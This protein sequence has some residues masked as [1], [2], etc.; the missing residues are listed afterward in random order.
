MV[1]GGKTKRG[2]LS[3]GKYVTAIIWGPLSRGN[4]SGD[5]CLGVIVSGQLFCGGIF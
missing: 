1:L 3:W 5:N 2:K 4:F